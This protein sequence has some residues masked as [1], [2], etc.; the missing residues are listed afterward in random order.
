MTKERI[1]SDEKMPVNAAGRVIARYVSSEW[2]KYRRTGNTRWVVWG[3]PLMIL[4]LVLGFGLLSPFVTPN[5]GIGL[6]FN[7]WAVVWLPFGTAILAA[8]SAGLEIWT[9]LLSLPVSRAGLYLAK[10]VVI[11]LQMALSTLA[12]TVLAVAVAH[13]TPVPWG[14]IFRAGGLLWLTAL[15]ELSIQLWV[16]VWG[17]YPASAVLGLAGLIVGA[18]CAPGPWWVYVPWSWPLRIL[19]PVTGVAPNGL[20]A[21]EALR[22]PGVLP[23]ALATAM[24]TAV[25]VT[26]LASVWFARR[27]ATRT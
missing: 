24:G 22:N 27:E 5:G 2:I 17:G 9:G 16:A 10:N 18:F 14:E 20:P 15:P 4:A 7:W 13:R 11:C 6:L 8:Q 1:L 19:G 12:L 3:A 25:V 23:V 21:D 26:L